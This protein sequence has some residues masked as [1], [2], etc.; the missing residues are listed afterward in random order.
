MKI[1]LKNVR[2]G[3]SPITNTIYVFAPDKTGAAKDKIDVTDQAILAVY[4]LAKQGHNIEV[5]DKE[6]G[7]TVHLRIEQGDEIAPIGVNPN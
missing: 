6:L 1:D 2:L 5:E 4:L 7:K 3:V